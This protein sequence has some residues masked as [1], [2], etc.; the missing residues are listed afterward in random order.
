MNSGRVAQM[1]DLEECIEAEKNVEDI[2]SIRKDIFDIL[3]V[4]IAVCTFMCIPL[5]I[6]GA[7]KQRHCSGDGI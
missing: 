2:Y 4:R 5:D 6:F 3:K 1:R 7:A